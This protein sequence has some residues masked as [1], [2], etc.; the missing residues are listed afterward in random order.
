MKQ[1]GWILVISGVALQII[2]SMQQSSAQLNNTQF[3]T[4]TIGAIVTPIEK[5][6]PIS[7]GLSLILAG[8]VC[9]IFD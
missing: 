1:A 4:T 7:L 2:E 9:F 3:A 8:G 5:F 6:L